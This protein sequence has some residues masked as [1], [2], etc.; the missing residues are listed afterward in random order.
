[1]ATSAAIGIK[2][3]D[4][5]VRATRLNR[6]GYPGYAGAILGGWSKTAEPIEALLGLGAL[7]ELNETPE[8]RV[9]YHRDRRERFKAPVTFETV[10]EY[11]RNG[12]SRMGAEYLYLYNEGKWSVYGL[13]NDPEWND[14][15]VIVGKQ[16]D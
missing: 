11:R 16:E 8:T 5:S 9:A 13:Y 14:L 1:M 3:A 15:D 7:R 10:E 4:G 2:L 12:E 6:D